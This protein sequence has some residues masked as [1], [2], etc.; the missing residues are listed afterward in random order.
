MKLY[1]L[2]RKDMPMS[3]IAVQAG[4]AVGAFCKA[5]PVSATVEWD[6]TLVYLGVGDEIELNSWLTLLKEVAPDRIV[7]WRESWWENS[8]TSFAVLGTPDVQKLVKSLKL[9]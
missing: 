4:H 6:D 9:I 7:E 2:V 3:H 5:L 1:V 8:L